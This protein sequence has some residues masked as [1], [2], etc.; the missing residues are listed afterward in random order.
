MKQKKGPKQDNIDEYNQ[1]L[2][3][4]AQ[5]LVAPEGTVLTGRL[6]PDDHHHLEV[7]F[8]LRTPHWQRGSER[9]SI[10]M[11]STLCFSS[12]CPSKCTLQLIDFPQK[13]G[14]FAQASSSFIA[15]ARCCE[16]NSHCLRKFST[17]SSTLATQS[18]TESVPI[19]VG[20]SCP[21]LRHIH[22]IHSLEVQLQER[23]KV[24]WG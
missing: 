16:H 4:F 17:S 1:P 2:V 7:L 20:G 19:C 14:G 22:V 9:E 5:A 24:A 23:T 6:P 10:V 21:S 8:C 18:Q 15:T 3:D 12:Q 11:S 13:L